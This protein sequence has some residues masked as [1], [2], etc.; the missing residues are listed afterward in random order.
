MTKEFKNLRELSKKIKTEGVKGVEST[1]NLFGLLQKNS[2]GRKGL[3][4]AIP[5]IIQDISTMRRD[6]VAM[7]HESRGSIVEAIRGIAA[8]SELAVGDSRP[9]EVVLMRSDILEAIAEVK[10]GLGPSIQKTAWTDVVKRRQRKPA[11][12]EKAV[13]AAPRVVPKPVQ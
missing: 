12:K 7:F 8:G 4:Q 3:R 10:T 13:P 2:N 6:V 9:T 5:D 11:K 1:Y